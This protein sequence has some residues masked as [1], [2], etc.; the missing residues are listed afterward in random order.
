[1][2]AFKFAFFNAVFVAGIVL[3]GACIIAGGL[4]LGAAFDFAR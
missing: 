2:S 4:D 1:M 3:V